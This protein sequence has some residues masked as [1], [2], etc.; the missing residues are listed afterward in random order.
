MSDQ[1]DQQ[2][3]ALV[4]EGDKKAFDRLVIKYQQRI[5][6]LVSRYISDAS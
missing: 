2:L 3:I 1:D 5:I 6:Q 4:K